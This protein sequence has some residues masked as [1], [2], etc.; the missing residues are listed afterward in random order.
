MN[1]VGPTG[2]FEKLKSA[3]L[4]GADEVF[5]GLKKFGAEEI[6]IILD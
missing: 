5:L 1:I 6:M 3:I 2:N 4:A